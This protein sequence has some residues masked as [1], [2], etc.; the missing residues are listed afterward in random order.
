MCGKLGK[1]SSEKATKQKV[2]I[3]SR[4]VGTMGTRGYRP[5]QHFN[6]GVLAPVVL[7]LGTC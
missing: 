7:N 1:A 3:L 4:E 6:W 5:P 2:L